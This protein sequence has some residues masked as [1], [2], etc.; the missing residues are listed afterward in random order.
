MLEG[1]ISLEQLMSE[2]RNELDKVRTLLSKLSA[3]P[4]TEGVRGSGDAYVATPNSPLPKA[5]RSQANARKN[6]KSQRLGY[7]LNTKK[8]KVSKI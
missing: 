8:Q 1:V 2:Q 7:S 3:V 6:T 4:R 5:Q